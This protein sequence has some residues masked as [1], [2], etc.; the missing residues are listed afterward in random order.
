MDRAVETWRVSDLER[1]FPRIHFPEYQREPNLWSLVEKQRLIDSML[2][3][4]DIASLYFYKHDDGSMD[5]VDGRQRTGAI[6][7][8][9]GENPKDE[10]DGGGGGFDFKILNEVY[11]DEPPTFESLQGRKLYDIRDSQDRDPEAKDFVE[12]FMSY[13]L[14]IVILSSSKRPEE[15]NLQFTRLNLGTIINSGEKLNAMVGDLRDRCFA[16]DEIGSHSF[17]EETSIPTRRYARAQV[18]AQ[19]LAQVFA[20]DENQ[21]YAR[22]RHFDL[23][24]LFKRHSSLSEAHGALIIRIR[25]LLDLL[26]EAFGDSRVLKNRALTVSTV[27]LAWTL[28]VRTSE[29]ASKLAEFVEEFVCRLKWQVRKGLDVDPEYRYLIDFQR[30]VTQASVE[31]AAVTARAKVL[32]HEWCRW[33][34]SRQLQGDEQWIERNPGQDPNVV[35]L[36]LL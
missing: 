22:T 14:T 15:F 1:K 3:Q 11:S 5:C 12:T 8:F 2:R 34:G 25:T 20:Y 35:C 26:G 21:E 18:A 31:K 29:E 33:V 16:E 10:R 27:L 6:M 9:L 23:Q 19:I 17:L 4:F 28:S 30:D 36:E 13:K 24:R 7:S 32:Q